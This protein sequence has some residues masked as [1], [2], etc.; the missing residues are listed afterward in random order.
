MTFF[1]GLAR[2]LRWLDDIEGSD[3]FADSDTP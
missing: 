2:L 3:L 1:R